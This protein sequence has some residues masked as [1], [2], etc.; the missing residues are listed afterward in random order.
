MSINVFFANKNTIIYNINVPIIA[1]GKRKSHSSSSSDPKSIQL[2][3]RVKE[4]PKEPFKVSNN[5]LF[6]YGC[7]EELNIKSTIIV[8]HNIIHS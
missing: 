1:R 4:H 2:A 5:R 6:C 3:Q 8:N 7:W